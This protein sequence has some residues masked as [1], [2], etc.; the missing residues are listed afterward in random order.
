MLSKELVDPELVSLVEAFPPF[1]LSREG[2]PE[3]RKQMQAIFAGSAALEAGV[4][5]T[6]RRIPP[7]SRANGIDLVIY[8]SRAARD[9]VPALLH[10]HGG[11]YIMGS[12][13][14]GHVRNCDFAVNAECVIVSVDYR[15]APENP[16]PS[17]LED[18]YSA[19]QW[20]HANATQL[21]IDRHRIGVVGESAGGGLAASLAQL[22]RDRAEIAICFQSLIYPMLDDR[23]GQ[24]NLEAGP[25]VGEFVWTGENNRFAWDALLGTRKSTQAP[26]RYAVP[27]RTPDLADLPPA[28]LA[29]GAV[30]LFVDETLQY[31]NRLILAGVPTELHLYPGA[32]HGFDL[33][34]NAGVA[35]R[36]RVDHLAATRRALGVEE[37][38]NEDR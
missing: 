34:A 3:L 11:G 28:F 31:A 25:G 19:L 10:F 38:S 36:F 9:A 14:M 15:L 4:E 2:L 26:P 6:K 22:A 1:E 32:V 37:K 33:V 30:D 23:T 16:F 17:A 27:A 13:V 12:P 5:L 24:L 18:A 35:R 8:R 7:T 20:V 21:K 29:V